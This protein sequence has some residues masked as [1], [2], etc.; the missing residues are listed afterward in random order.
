MT[1]Y[2]T[3]K[4][5]EKPSD[6]GIFSELYAYATIIIS[7]MVFRMDTA[8]FRFAAQA[9]KEEKEK[10]YANSFYILASITFIITL[11]L[12][13]FK[14]VIASALGYPDQAYYVTWFAFILFLDAITT[15]QCCF[16]GLFCFD[17]SGN[18]SQVF[19]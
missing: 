14:N 7:L 8:Y 18:S 13:L 16:H 12:I 10:I 19:P 6:F 5:N 17:F 11:I 4:F 9:E 2:L 3:Y 1:V 15:C